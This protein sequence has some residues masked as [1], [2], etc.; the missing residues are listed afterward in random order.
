[1][2]KIINQFSSYL[3]ACKVNDSKANYTLSTSNN[4]NNNNNNVT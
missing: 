4:N 2:T 1:M 3:F